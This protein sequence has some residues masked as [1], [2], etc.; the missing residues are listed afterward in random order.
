MRSSSGRGFGRTKF[1]P[2]KVTYGEEHQPRRAGKQRHVEIRD[3][4]GGSENRQ[5]RNDTGN[6]APD[7][8][9]SDARNGAMFLCHAQAKS[10][11]RRQRHQPDK[12][13]AKKRHADQKQE[14]RLLQGL[15]KRQRNGHAD[16]RDKNR[17][18]RH[19]FFAEPA[20]KRRGEAAPGER[21]K[22]ARGKIEITQ[23]T[24]KRRRQYHEIHDVACG[25]NPGAFEDA[26]EGTLP[27]TDFRPGHYAD[28][29]RQPS[30]VKKREKTEGAAQRAGHRRFRIG[31]FARGD[32]DNFQSKK[33]KDGH[34]HA[35]SDT[36]PTMRRK[37]A[38]R[39]EIIQADARKA[40]PE[41][42]HRAK[43]QKRD[44]GHH[45]NHREPVFD[46]SEIFDAHGVDQNQYRGKAA[47]PNPDRHARRPEITINGSGNNFAADD[48]HKA[49]PVG[50]A[51]SEPG[52]GMQ[53]HFRVQAE[54]AGGWMLD[55]HFRQR[56]HYR[57]SNHRSRGAAQNHGRFGQLHADRAS[58]KKSRADGAA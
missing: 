42:Q 5:Q 58:E 10:D 55:R 48:H 15:R 25:R 33:T 2:N 29:Q 3:P 54:G 14:C 31:G 23:R 37:S 34:H 1:S 56:P 52:P 36:S 26:H 22:H 51:D 35:E 24:E 49:Q 38:M 4:P 45:L 21:K 47:D 46:G 44:D 40:D 41:Q 18:N 12:W 13:P 9:R 50:V 17:G 7:S 8:H 30:E 6:G 27:K 43:N 53:I 28:H 11:V 32:A 16:A 39:G 57:E 19:A 20:K